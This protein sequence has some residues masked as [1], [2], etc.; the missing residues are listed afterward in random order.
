MNE[1][2]SCEEARAYIKLSK[3]T[4]YLYVRKGIIP[5]FK[6]GRLWRFKKKNLDEW[7]QTQIEYETRT[8]TELS[9]VEQ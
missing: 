9:G 5:A 1:V 4:L 3:S 7:I 8:R 2:L 6:V